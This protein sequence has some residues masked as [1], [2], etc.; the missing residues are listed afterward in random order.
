MARCPSGA[1]LVLAVVSGA[2]AQ[3]PSMDFA[4]ALEQ[5]ISNHAQ[6]A[7]DTLPTW[8]DSCLPPTQKI[9]IQA[10]VYETTLAPMREQ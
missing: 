5:C 1:L 4:N 3:N 10:K 7:I 6:V 8:A 2:A 9:D